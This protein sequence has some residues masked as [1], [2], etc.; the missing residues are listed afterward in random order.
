[1][2]L[3]K[4]LIAVPA[5]ALA[6]GLGLAACGSSGS[7]SG[8]SSLPAPNPV[9]QALAV[10][11]L[12]GNG[13]SYNPTGTVSLMN[14]TGMDGNAWSTGN[15]DT[16]EAVLVFD[17]VTDATTADNDM[18]QYENSNSGGANVV[19]NGVAVTV[20]G[21]YYPN[22]PT[23]DPV[24]NAVIMGSPNGS[25]STQAPV[26]PAPA[27]S[28]A[29]APAPTEAPAAAPTQAPAPAAPAPVYVSP[30][31]SDAWSTAV[32]YTN[33][34]NAGDNWAAWNLLSPSLQSSGWGSYSTFVADFTPL[35]FD[36]VTESSES[37][38]SVTFTFTLDNHSTGSTKYTVCTYTVDDGII[39]T[40][41]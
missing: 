41:T 21:P 20:S 9:A 5:I 12:E 26:I 17:N 35:S 18:T 39:T 14:V 37:G 15:I 32:A 24:V 29:P 28:S 19:Q 30:A 11:T 27:P 1:M 13:F 2:K 31:A 38:D 40:S 7:G 4:K 8:G 3:N 36:N 6:A 16:Q 25:P 10:K 22:D 23:S 33:D 34:V